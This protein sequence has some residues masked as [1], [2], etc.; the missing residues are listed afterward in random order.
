MRVTRAWSKTLLITPL[1]HIR[2]TLD[3]GGRVGSARVRGQLGRG[4]REHP[5]SSAVKGSL[6]F[7]LDQSRDMV[8]HGVVEKVRR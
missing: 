3:A 6:G 1:P 2:T 8:S 4:G 5:C 7:P